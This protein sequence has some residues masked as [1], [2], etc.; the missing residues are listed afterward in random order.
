VTSRIAAV[1]PHPYRAF[2]HDGWQ[3]A[4]ARYP[5]SFA[6]AT[7][8]YVD[9]LLAAVDTGPG[10]RLLD[11]ACGSG[12]VAAAAVA[13]GS[14]VAGVD[15]SPAMLAEARRRVPDAEWHEA[16]AEA[17]PIAD[18]SVDA[19]VSNFGLHHFPFPT[20]ALAEARRVLRPG[21]RLAATVWAAPDA[22]PGWRI[23]FDA[24]A[25]HGDPAIPLPTAPLGRLN[26][27]EDCLRVMRDAGFEDDQVSVRVVRATWPL[28]SPEHLIDG[29]LAGTVR[30]AAL[31]AAQT[32]DARSNIRA[33]VAAAVAAHT[34]AD[35]YAVPTA[36]LLISAVR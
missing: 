20:R 18:G 5:A 14:T 8:A 1:E 6:H 33:A 9:A 36:A 2:E 17:L 32:P 13:R 19:V 15:F 21:G 29:F 12:V 23:V 27:T 34:R 35:G 7:A 11:V 10:R 4:A 22:N 24:I 31:I 16:D 30:M 28:A 25:A 3:S 26:R